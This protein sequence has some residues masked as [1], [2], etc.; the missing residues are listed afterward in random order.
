VTDWSDMDAVRGDGRRSQHP[1]RPVHIVM[2]DD[3]AADVAFTRDVLAEYRV[4]NRLTVLDDGLKAVRYLRRL[5]PYPDADRPDLVLLDLNLPGVDGLTLLDLIRADPNLRN[6]PVAVLTTAPVDQ[7]ILRQ[8]G[9]PA[10][11]FLLKPVDF[12]RLVEAIRQVDGLYL[13]VERDGYAQA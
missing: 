9:V 1:A 3:D 12:D 8:R 10:N 13:Q 6:L 5:A 4:S 7:A 2:I 11:C